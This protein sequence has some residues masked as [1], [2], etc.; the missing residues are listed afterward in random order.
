MDLTRKWNT[1][2]VVLFLDFGHMQFSTSR[3]N[4]DL[5]ACSSFSAPHH[6]FF[7]TIWQKCN[8][9]SICKMGSYL[10]SSQ[11]G[12]ELESILDLSLLL[13]VKLLFKG[14]PRLIRYALKIRRFPL[15]IV[16]HQK[17]LLYILSHKWDIDIDMKR[18]LISDQKHVMVKH[19]TH[20]TQVIVHYLDV[21]V[22]KMFWGI[23]KFLKS[24]C[25]LQLIHIHITQNRE[26]RE[27]IKPEPSSPSCHLYHNYFLTRTCNNSFKPAQKLVCFL[28]NTPNPPVHHNTIVFFYQP[29]NSRETER[30]EERGQTGHFHFMR[31]SMVSQKAVMP[32]PILSLV[33]HCLLTISL[34]IYQNV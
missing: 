9:L 24:F 1:H 12:S 8:E 14:Q 30:D 20:N 4:V 5:I 28:S 16:I 31:Q 2:S 29:V 3:F 19:R 7:F 32:V 33:S 21:H 25:N 23:L 17:G 18:H 10:L 13:N 26:H 34:F 22:I 15:S 11:Y 6:M 27:K